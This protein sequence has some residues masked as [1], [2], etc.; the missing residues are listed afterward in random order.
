[1]RVGFGGSMRKHVFGIAVMLLAAIAAGSA[2]AADLP[3]APQVYAPPPVV[4]PPPIYSW[5]GCYLGIEGGGVLGRTQEINGGG[6]NPA[7]VG[8][9]MTNSFNV[10]GALVG[11]TVGCNYQ[12]SSAVVGVEDDFSWTNASG[13]SPDIAP[14]PAATTNT[15]KQEWLDTLRGRI[16]FAWDQFLIYGTGGAA[17]ADINASACSGAGFCVSGSQTRTGWTAGVGG[18]WAVWTTAAGALTFKAE[19]L[20]VDLG[21]STFFNPPIKVGAGTFDTRNAKLT[22]DILRA[23]VNWKFNWP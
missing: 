20:H 3:P 2:L 7:L 21:T 13:S 8:V 22:D 14:F 12:I 17:F 18:E 19:Y 4:V 9:P 23:G 5:T 1:V 15:V 16:G 11:G 10:D 6:P